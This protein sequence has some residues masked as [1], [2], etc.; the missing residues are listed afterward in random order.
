MAI[1][2][3]CCGR[4]EWFAVKAIFYGKMDSRITAICSAE[5]ACMDDGCM[6]LGAMA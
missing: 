3:S 1:A 5:S 4:V 2:N 6:S